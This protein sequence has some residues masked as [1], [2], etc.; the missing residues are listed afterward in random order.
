MSTGK[1]YLATLR[2]PFTLTL[3][4]FTASAIAGYAVGGTVAPQ[5]L[6][7]LQETFGGIAEMPP[8]IL[9]AII[10]LNN[11]VKSLAALILGLFFGIPSVLFIILNGAIIGIVAY[12]VSTIHGLPFVLAALIPH[13]IF[14]LPAV[15]L[16]AAIG[17]KLGAK[18]LNRLKG[19]TGLKG[20]FRSGV[21]FFATR[22][23]PLLIIAAVIEVFVT[24]L[25]I[26]RLLPR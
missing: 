22:I 3:T 2:L 12:E 14:E 19:E 20:E 1:S 13:G 25:V 4:I 26:Y 24:P 23:I 9:L 21:R 15:L 18:V 17:I 11:A 8:L 7:I 5:L 16:S 10:F 6:E